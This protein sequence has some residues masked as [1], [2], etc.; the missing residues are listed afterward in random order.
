MDA[1]RGSIINVSST[2]GMVGMSLI[3]A[4]VA[5][6]WGLRGVT[7]TAAIE[8]GPHGVRVNSLHP[9]GVATPMTNAHE[10][11]MV[12]PPPAGAIDADPELAAADARSAAQPIPRTGRPIEIARLALF[13]ASDESSYCTGMEFVADGG[14]VAGQ[15]L[16]DALASD[17]LTRRRPARASAADRGRSGCRARRRPRTGSAF[18]QCMAVARM[19]SLRSRSAVSTLGG[20]MPWKLARSGGSAS[21]STS[22]RSPS[23]PNVHGG[24]RC[25]SPIS[26]LTRTVT[27]GAPSIVPCHVKRWA[28]TVPASMTPTGVSIGSVATAI[29]WR[30][31][32]LVVER[33]AE[34]VGDHVDRL[35]E[36]VARGSPASGCRARP[37]ASCRTAS[38]RARRTRWRRCGCRRTPRR[39]RGGCCDRSA[40]SISGSCSVMPPGLMPVPC[41]VT[42]ACAAR[43]LDRRDVVAAER[44][45]PADRRDDVL[46]RL[47]QA[48]HLARVR[49]ASGCRR[50]SRRRGARIASTSFGRDDPDRAERRRSRRRR[51]PPCR[52]CRRSRRPARGRDGRGPP[53]SAA[54]PTLPV[55]HWM[56]R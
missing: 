34:R 50:R 32:L 41:S 18:T 52:R 21:N 6:K 56:T 30:R 28:A 35:A 2:G 5:S 1:G 49:R 13:L 29:S 53:R 40:E 17:R 48:D 45:D 47:E 43:G 54:R 25:S 9:G 19:P 51:V 23:G 37:R 3:G 55:A 31:A 10:P 14:S 44:I 11:V 15:D 22:K 26:Q 42:L 7:K 46:A 16:T 33:D 20:C 27:N 8:F 12:E 4:Y 38:R 24:S 36:A 39:A